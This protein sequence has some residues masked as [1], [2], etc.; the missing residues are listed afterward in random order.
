MATFA[1]SLQGTTP[2]TIEATDKLQFAGGTF[3]SAIAITEYN[4]S[5]HVESS[6]GADDSSA[7]TPKNNKFISQTG[8]AGGKSQVDV[9]AGTVLLDAVAT[10]SCALKIVFS[11]ASSV[12]TSGAKFYAYDG[13]T[14]ATAPANITVKAA[15]QGDANFTDA[16]GSGSPVTLT[17]Q[18]AG[19]THNFYIIVSA[20]P[21]TVGEKTA[22]AFRIELTYV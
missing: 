15:E 6:V 11:D 20:S 21:D 13:T 7:N 14:P 8:G 3:D 22:F 19:T 10:G 12:A 2:T 9:G 18:S 5:T 17:D 4:S 16:E 1:F